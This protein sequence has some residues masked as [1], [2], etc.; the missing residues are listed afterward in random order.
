MSDQEKKTS[1]AA[2]K[3]EPVKT[4]KVLIMEEE[5]FKKFQVLLNEFPGKF[6]NPVLTVL[7]KYVKDVPVSEN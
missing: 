3:A 2:P 4:K 7:S 1:K 6:C 5:D